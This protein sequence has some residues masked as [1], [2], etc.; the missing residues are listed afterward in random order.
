MKGDLHSRVAS[1]IGAGRRGGYRLATELGHRGI[2]VNAV[3]PGP[4]DTGWMGEELR[5]GLRAKFP[6]G[7]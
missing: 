7:G 2:T 4:T 5:D 1:V 6:R 3:N